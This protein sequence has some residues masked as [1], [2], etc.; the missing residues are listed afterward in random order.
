MSDRLILTNVGSFLP[1]D[2]ER[3]IRQDAPM[4]VYRNPALARA[5][6]NLNMIDTQGG[7]IK[8]MFQT[9]MRRSFP[10]P[11]YDLSNPERVAVSIRG[12]ILNEQYTRMLMERTDLDLWAVVLLDK[13]Q[14]EIRVEREAHQWLK[15]LG[16]VEGRYPNIY[17]SGKVAAVTNQKAK[18]IRSRGL[19]RQYYKDLIFELIRQ[20]GPVPREEINKLL[21]GKLPE[22]LTQEQKDVLIHNLLTELRIMKVVN[23]VGSRRRPMWVKV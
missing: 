11:D 19:N 21:M 23:N 6:V 16:L 22:V 20:H 18:H 17:I 3:V 2:V 9:Q 8:R 4:E 1:G 12:T 10:L 7:G 14:K 15:K 13:V 5:M